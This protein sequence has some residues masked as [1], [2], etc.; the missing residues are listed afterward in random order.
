LWRFYAPSF[1][2]KYFHFFEDFFTFSE[3]KWVKTEKVLRGN[4]DRPTN[5]GRL[6]F[7]L[8]RKRKRKS[9]KG[10]EKARKACG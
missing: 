8:C 7:K 4:G 2:L 6:G 9:A 3:K 5:F 1:F 10:G